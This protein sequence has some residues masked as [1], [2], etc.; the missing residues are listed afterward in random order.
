MEKIKR[1]NNSRQNTYGFCKNLTEQ[2]IGS[3]HMRPYPVCISRLTG[4]G[5]IAKTPCPGY[6]GNSA[7]ATGMILSIACGRQADTSTE[8]ILRV[9]M[10]IPL[11]MALSIPHPSMLCVTAAQ[12]LYVPPQTQSQWNVLV[13]H[14]QCQ[15]VCSGAA[16]Y[17][18]SV[19][20]DRMQVLSPSAVPKCCL[21]V[22]Q[23]LFDAN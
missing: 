13:L 12:C 18:T 4:V 6:I 2:L 7:A 1:Q 5:A 9:H 15:L 19:R 3:Y 16:P 11:I 21:Q 14:S 8:H 17:L 20:H 22:L 10:Y 23:G